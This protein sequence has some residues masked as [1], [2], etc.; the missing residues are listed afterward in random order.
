MGDINVDSGKKTKRA[1]YTPVRGQFD[2]GN[3]EEYFDHQNRQIT[4]NNLGMNLPSKYSLF[5]SNIKN[6]HFF[7]DENHQLIHRYGCSVARR[8]VQDESQSEIKG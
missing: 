6:V 1:L 8:Q 5:F 4:L 7:S 3:P 2:Q